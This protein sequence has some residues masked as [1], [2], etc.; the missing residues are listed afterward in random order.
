MDLTTPYILNF[1]KG[2]K[3]YTQKMCCLSFV[4]NV[5]IISWLGVLFSSFNSQFN[6]KILLGLVLLLSITNLQL[7]AQTIPETIKNAN[8]LLAANRPTA[9]MEKYR[10]AAYFSAKKE[11]PYIWFKAAEI[12][13]TKNL[14]NFTISVCDSVLSC[15]S[16]DTLLV[17]KT[18]LLK[19]KHLIL[20]EQFTKAEQN[21]SN[22]YLVS[23]SE[24]QFDEDLLLLMI[25]IYSNKPD[26]AEKLC[27]KLSKDSLAVKQIF[28]E[29]MNL[30]KIN[31]ETAA[32]LSALLPG[33]GQLYA[34]FP[35][36]AIKTF[37]LNAAL[38][39][40]FYDLSVNYFWYSGFLSIYPWF[41]RYYVANVKNA[42]KLS[43]E[44]RKEKKDKFVTKLIKFVISKTRNK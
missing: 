44:K 1:C 11:K 29:Y 5:F 42:E 37:V 21:L 13:D 41:Q 10:R 40:V 25:K 20:T 28:S 16:T 8:D 39:T 17:I 2:T 34:G 4:C 30:P 43:F 3:F 7:S 14:S 26:E 38:F 19:I 32:N 36:K 24:F 31:P 33:A 9:A 22:S 27:T 6:S 15:Q 12:S 35:D 23:S 18:L